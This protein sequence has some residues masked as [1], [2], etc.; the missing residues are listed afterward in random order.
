M[1]VCDSLSCICLFAVDDLFRR[2]DL[3][4]HAKTDWPLTYCLRGT[5]YLNQAIH[6]AFY[7]L[8]ARPTTSPDEECLFWPEV[9]AFVHYTSFT[10]SR[11]AALCNKGCMQSGTRFISCI[12]YPAVHWLIKI[13]CVDTRPFAN[14]G[15][16]VCPLRGRNLLQGFVYSTVCLLKN[17]LYPSFEITK[18]PWMLPKAFCLFLL[19]LP[20]LSGQQQHIHLPLRHPSN[21]PSWPFSS[22]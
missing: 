12:F 8:P 11:H 4:V 18:Q 13:G 15:V 21:S 3:V 20:C 2:V 22:L 19:P 16:R 5:T 14:G 1:F 10:L 7:Q 9:Y 6:A 17:T